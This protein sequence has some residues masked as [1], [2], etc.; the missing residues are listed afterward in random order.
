MV[1]PHGVEN[2]GADLPVLPEHVISGDGMGFDQR[3]FARIQT[4][5]LVE[6]L[7]WD[8]RFAY[9]MKHRGRIKPFDVDLWHAEAQPEI[10]RDACHQQAMLIRSLMVTANS[11]EP[12]GEPVFGD[13][14]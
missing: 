6:D 5:G 1:M 11:G 4:S 12:V 14:V 13:R 10:D 3:A 9:I 2:L 7:E 8:L